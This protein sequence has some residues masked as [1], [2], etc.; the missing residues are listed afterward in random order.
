MTTKIAKKKSHAFGGGLTF[1]WVF[2]ALLV[3]LK[4]QRERERERERDKVLVVTCC[5]DLKVL[6]TITHLHSDLT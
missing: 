6:E 1:N 4:K 5:E 2:L 3:D